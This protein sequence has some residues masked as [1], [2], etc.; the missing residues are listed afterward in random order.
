MSLSCTASFRHG[1]TDD[2]KKLTEQ[3]IELFHARFNA[4]RYGEIYETAHEEFKHS[5][6]DADLLNS[7]KETYEQFG[8]MDH[9][10]EKW[11]NV[12]VRNRVEIRAVYNTRFTK[13]DAT[14]MFVFVKDGNVIKL[15]SYQ[16]SEGTVKAK[17]TEP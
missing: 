10:S 14:E 12:F 11:I 7:M 2:D 17:H 3:A 9:V 5:R 13:A 16:I 1:N 15:V 8:R 6:E 4:G